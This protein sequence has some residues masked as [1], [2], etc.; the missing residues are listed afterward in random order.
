[1][2]KLLALCLVLILML[3]AC[4]CGKEEKVEPPTP[5]ANPTAP[6]VSTV[7]ISAESL[8]N[9][10]LINARAND[11]STLELEENMHLLARAVLPGKNTTVDHWEINGK[12]VDS[13]GRRY[14]LEFDTDETDVVSAI[15]REKKSVACVNSYIT[16]L[17][18][19]GNDI[20]KKY[21]RVRFED[22]YTIPV[23]G[24]AHA[25]GTITCRITAAVPAGME[26]D[27]WLFNGVAY[28]FD[29]QNVV[30]FVVVGL[31]VDMVYEP[32]FCPATGRAPIYSI[33]EAFDPGFNNINTQLF[34]DDYPSYFDD[35][36]EEADPS[37]EGREDYDGPVN[38]GTQEAPKEHE[39]N[40]QLDEAAS[41][42]DNGHVFACQSSYTEPHSY[43][44]KGVCTVCGH[45]THIH[46]VKVVPK[47]KDK[48]RGQGNSDPGTA[49]S[50]IEPN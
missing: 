50:W 5:V 40:F 23:T 21:K 41:Q 27:Y 1:M 25:G 16:F 13:G 46:H 39:H 11:S 10:M 37:N 47:H 49:P 32:I 3:S 4:A 33:I 18:S 14:T 12:Q 35:S 38:T 45:Q 8:K 2:K 24:E 42:T 9:V 34:D 28:R 43:D 36:F 22:D 30:S 20:G 6:T 7:Y 44:E 31:N 17:D 26:V 29:N 48:S 19:K 15:L